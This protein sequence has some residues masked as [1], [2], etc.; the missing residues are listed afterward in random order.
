MP[1]KVRRVFVPVWL[2]P[3][4]LTRL[5]RIVREVS[6]RHPD[7]KYTRTHA[8]RGA[9]MMGVAAME[10]YLGIGVEGGAD[11]DHRVKDR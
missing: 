7:L 11:E 3:S 1:G 2:A 8:L 9:V 5:D 4:W 10:V 6:A